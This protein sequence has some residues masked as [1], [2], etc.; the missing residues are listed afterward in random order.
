MFLV[1]IKKR[2]KVF[3]R[4]SQAVDYSKFQT[5]TFQDVPLAKEY[6][7]KKK[8]IIKVNIYYNDNDEVKDINNKVYTVYKSIKSGHPFSSINT[9]FRRKTENDEKKDLVQKKQ[10]K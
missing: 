5:K 9:T 10:L 6:Y 3:K 8:E 7:E 2:T 4:P 1:I